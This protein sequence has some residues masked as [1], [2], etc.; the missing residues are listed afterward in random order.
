MEDGLAVETHGYAPRPGAVKQAPAP[1]A[2]PTRRRRRARGCLGT[3]AGVLAALALL[4]L[5]RAPLL[6]ALA[7]YLVVDEPLQ[8][9]DAIF[10]F[11]GDAGVRP[12]AAAAL[13]RRGLAPRVLLPR[14]E[15]TRL[16]SD[17]IEPTQTEVFLRVLA[18]EGVP[19]GAIGVL[20]SPRGSGST[21]QDARLLAGW[22]RAHP[23]QRVIAVTTRFHSRRARLALRRSLP[24]GARVSLHAAPSARF[25]EHNWW[26]S[27]DGLVVYFEEYLKLLRDWLGAGDDGPTPEPAQ[28]RPGGAG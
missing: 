12:Y 6:T 10:I 2:A 4:W 20:E 9:A 27:E 13:Y 16:A 11:G 19:A 28:P 25:N 18:R 22:L 23:G 8:R 24:A 15:R 21:R 1:A 7:G 17:G 5:L 14:T 3:L 26:R